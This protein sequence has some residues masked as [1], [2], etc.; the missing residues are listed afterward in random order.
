MS[1]HTPGPWIVSGCCVYAECQLDKDGMTSEQP[2]FESAGGRDDDLEGNL[3]LVEAAPKL[4]E[5]CNEYLI[6]LQNKVE[7]WGERKEHHPDWRYMQELKA[8][9]EKAKGEK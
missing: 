6:D 3:K 2:I 8:L 5:A 1:N 7:G 4:L 9:I